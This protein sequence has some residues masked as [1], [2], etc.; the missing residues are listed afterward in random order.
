MLPCN[1]CGQEM[2][3]NYYVLPF[4]V[5]ALFFVITVLLMDAKTPFFLNVLAFFMCILVFYISVPIKRVNE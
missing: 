4:I 1:N 3:G 5:S 2:I